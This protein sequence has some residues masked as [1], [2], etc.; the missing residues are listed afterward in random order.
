MCHGGGV[1]WVLFWFGFDWLDG[2]DGSLLFCCLVVSWLLRMSCTAVIVLS[3]LFGSFR[4]FPLRL[5]SVNSCSS[6]SLWSSFTL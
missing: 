5:P 6:F 2:S 3:S 4:V 1:S